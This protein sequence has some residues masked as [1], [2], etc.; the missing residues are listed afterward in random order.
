MTAY[1]IHPLLGALLS[2]IGSLPLGMINMTVAETAMR[3]GMRSATRVAFG[4]AFIEFLQAFL[5]IKFTDFL[6]GNTTFDMAFHML[7]FIVFFALTNYYLIFAKPVWPKKQIHE[8]TGVKGFR[9]GLWISSL[10]VMVF[11]YW[12]FY[13]TYLSAQGWLQLQ[14]LYIFLFC[15][16]VMAG[17]FLLLFMYAKLGVFVFNK[18]KRM[19]RYTNQIIGVI[20]MLFTCYEAL[21]IGELL[22]AR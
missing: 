7:A 2:F 20:F 17:T 13:S 21:K 12:I 18:A 1:L 6:L 5:V 8:Q 10:N 15:A 4:A 14:N 22:G 19:V 3:R 11:P 9:R 16:G